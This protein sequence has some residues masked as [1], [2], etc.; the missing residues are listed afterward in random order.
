MEAEDS[1]NM[2]NQYKQIESDEV[3]LLLGDG[4]DVPLTM[5]N[6]VSTAGRERGPP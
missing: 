2:S 4:V 3:H 1:Y 6:Y 5:A